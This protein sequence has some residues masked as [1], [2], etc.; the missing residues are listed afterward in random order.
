MITRREIKALRVAEQVV[1]TA[2]HPDTGEFIPYSLRFTTFIPMQIPITL[3]LILPAPTPVN[4]IAANWANQTYNAVTN[5]GNRNASST[6]S[7]SDIL[8]SYTLAAGS[9]CLVALGIRKAVENQTKTM[10]G[11]KLLFVNSASSMVACA[12]AG[13]LNTWFMRT[14]EMQK[15][16]DIV[17]PATGE[18]MGKSAVAGKKAVLETALSRTLISFAILLPTSALLL[19]E[20]FALMPT[21]F[22][23][24]TVL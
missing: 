14:T 23:P 19:I 4:T 7:T 10:T 13:F 21:T 24:Q 20:K 2:I 17:D 9:S 1:S 11:S 8:K 6:Y 22:V 16:I 12:V 3:S 15:G 18:V 5:Y